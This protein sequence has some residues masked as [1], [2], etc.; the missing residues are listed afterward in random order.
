MAVKTIVALACAVAFAQEQPSSAPTDDQIRHA[1]QR[2][3]ATDAKTLWK[4]IYKLRRVRINRKSPADSVRKFVTFIGDLDRIALLAADWKRRLKTLTVEDVNSR[5][6][7][8]FTEVRLDCDADGI[9]VGRVQKWSAPVV[10]MVLKADG[11]VI[12]PIAEKLGESSRTTVMPQT[13]G[14]VQRNG[15]LV[16]YT[17]LYSTAIY[18]SATVSS[19]FRFPAIA[20]PTSLS[21]VVISGENKT[22][23]KELDPAVLTP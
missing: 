2:G 4:E 19:W 22:K 15:P 13:T 3:E 14:I 6:P 16:T 1:I 8:G 17:P 9:Y 20:S 5:I 21:V 18:D 10:H 23:E 12:Q 11:A 7:L